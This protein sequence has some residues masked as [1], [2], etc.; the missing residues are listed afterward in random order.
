MATVICCSESKR[1]LKASGVVRSQL[2]YDL[3]S[4]CVDEVQVAVF[5][6]ETK[7]AVIIG[8]AALLPSFMGRSSFH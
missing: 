3:A 1:R 4:V 2:S 7:L 6:A 8:V 5:V